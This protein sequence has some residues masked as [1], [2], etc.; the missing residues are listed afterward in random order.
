[1][2]LTYDAQVDSLYLRLSDS[3]VFES[4][5]VR[6]GVVTDLN[7]ADEV[8]AIEIRGVKRLHPSFDPTRLTVDLASTA[9][10]GG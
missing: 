9:E 10:A 3:P 8:V 6:P 4:Q 1:M 5:E 2:K 7:E